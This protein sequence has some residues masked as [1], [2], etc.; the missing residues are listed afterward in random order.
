MGLD[1]VELETPQA[2]YRLSIL[3]YPATAMFLTYVCQSPFRPDVS[4]WTVSIRNAPVH[5]KL[6]FTGT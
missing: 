2:M 5:E 1:S 3:N 4:H 6:I